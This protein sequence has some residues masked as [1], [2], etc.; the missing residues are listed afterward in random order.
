MKP[1]VRFY[2]LGSVPDDCL[3]YAVVSA[4]CAEAQVLCRHRERSSWECPGGHI[5][6]GESPVEAASRELYE[7]TGARAE[8]LEPVC[9]YSV[10]FGS[11][12]E[13]FGLLCRAQITQP[14]K[15]PA[16][17]E[18]AEA[19]CF[20][21]AP[22][23][24][25]YP[26]IQP[27]LCAR[28]EVSV[29]SLREHPAYFE[30]ALDYIQR[31]WA[32]EQ[33]MAVYEDCLSHVLTPDGV[34]PQWY[35]LMDGSEPIGCAGLIPNDFI[36][37]MDLFPWLCALFVEESRRGQAY[38]SM[39]IDRAQTDAQKAGFSRLYLCTD[40]VGYYEKYGFSY[41]GDGYHPW[42]ESSRIYMR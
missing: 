37:R 30:L 24:W 2:P 16:N 41:I 29:L 33:T 7:E 9:V 23:N 34:L 40:H 21:I 14:G 32:S 4:R 25:T 11:I 1:A 19:R 38:G 3:K 18:M 42:G 15:L 27:L 13:T 8:C 28:A 6:A 26:H 35:L 22:D 17:S 36:S 12:P 10:Q 5:E 20:S 39:L 31:H